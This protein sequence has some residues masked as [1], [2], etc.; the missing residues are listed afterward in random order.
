M[1]NPRSEGEKPEL[2][3]ETIAK[4]SG[5]EGGQIIVAPIG[6]IGLLSSIGG[7]TIAVNFGRRAIEET[8]QGNLES[9]A[10]N[11]GAAVVSAVAAAGGA[12]LFG[13]IYRG[14]E[15]FGQQKEAHELQSWR[16]KQRAIFGYPPLPFTL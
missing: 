8:L 3:V 7:A 5:S 4:L 15:R 11:T 12:V 9:A 2:L 1:A 13:V 10:L 16:D 14:I 6:G